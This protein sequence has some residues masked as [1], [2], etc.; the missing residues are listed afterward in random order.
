MKQILI[1]LLV[2]AGVCGHAQSDTT[3]KVAIVV[4]G[5]F[6]A[7]ISIHE[8]ALP[9]NYGVLVHEKKLYAAYTVYASVLFKEKIGF[10]LTGGYLGGST[11]NSST[12]DEYVA[13]QFPN[14]HYLPQYSVL[15]AGYH[16]Q[17]FVP[18]ASYRLGSEPF[19]ATFSLG[20]GFGR[21]H[22]PHGNVILQ[23]DGSNDFI[24]LTYHGQNMWNYHGQLDM[25]FAYMRQLSQHL[26]ANVGLYVTSVALMSN[27]EF[28]YTETDY[29][30]TYSV[31][32]QGHS[33]DLMMHFN[34]G[35]FLN[36]QW[37]KRES[38]RAYYE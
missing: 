34:T 38:A 17:Y 26:F 14:Y 9:H 22:T 28:H 4:G 11:A 20:A 25:E 3:K 18:Q 7:G 24:E 23:K 12:I 29:Q 5:S 31:L 10:R 1:V 35:L 36:F 13:I 8:P 6:G 16:Y 27:Y 15:H 37:N 33:N 21:L 19:N 2:V 32:G 30:Q